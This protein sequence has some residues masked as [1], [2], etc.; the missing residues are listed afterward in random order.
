VRLWALSDLHVGYAD[1]RAALEQIPQYPGDRILIAG[2]VGEKRAH[3]EYALRVL[4]DRFERVYWVPGNHELYAIDPAG[5]RGEAL[6]QRQC[7]LARELGAVTPEDPWEVVTIAGTDYVIALAFVGYDYSFG[8]DGL[9]PAA[10]VQWAAEAGIRC[11]DEQY[12]L[13]D[14]YPT[15]ADWCR[16][17][18][19]ATEARLSAVTAGRIVLVAHW[20]LRLDLV[21][22]MRIP[23][24]VPWCGTRATEDWHRRY[25]IEVV[26]GGHLHMRATDWRDGVRFEEV[27][28]G[29]PRHWRPEVGAA[30]YLRPIL[31]ACPERW[32]P[33]RELAPLVGSGAAP[34][35]IF[36]GGTVWYR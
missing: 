13:P 8:P 23:R 34:Q 28:L 12:L 9:P 25:P 10:V 17:R 4:R 16:A 1:N 22:L 36:E 32:D 5:P 35:R 18:V 24:F 15:R 3:L 11:T 31:P 7:E 26:V 14:P 21:R 29:Y 20:P 30:G 6:Y 27:S 33:A 2:D 19:A